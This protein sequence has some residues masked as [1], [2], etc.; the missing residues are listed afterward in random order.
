MHNLVYC[1]LS[2][3]VAL[4]SSSPRVQLHKTKV[5]GK[6]ITGLEQDFFGGIPYAEPP[7]GPL[8]LQPPVF[9]PDP[10]RGVFDASRFRLSCLQPEISYDLISEDRF[11]RAA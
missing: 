4:V 1:V 11:V 5:V 6:A 2:L 10:D 3:Y 7:I 8:H 9:K